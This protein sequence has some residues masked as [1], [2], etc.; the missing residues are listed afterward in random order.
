MEREALFF[1]I[2][3]GLFGVVVWLSA[4]F[5]TPR[6]MLPRKTAQAAC[7]RLVLPLFAAMLLLAFLCG[8]VLQ[9]PDPADEYAGV[10][11]YLLAAISS[12]IMVRAIVRSVRALRFP[13]GAEVPV[14]T[15]GLLRPRIAVSDEFR[16]LVSPNVLAAALA[17]ENAHVR[18]YDPLRIWLA[19]FVADLQW[20]IPGCSHRF[21]AW[22][23]ALEV[24][25]DDEALAN[26]ANREDLAE[27]ILTAIRLQSRHSY[28]P[29]AAV[30]GAKEHI[31][32]RIRRL[33]AN[34]GSS[35]SGRTNALLVTLLLC[36]MLTGAAIW[37]GIEIGEAALRCLP[38]VGS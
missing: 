28:G 29:C 12:C 8:W 1:V 36:V 17:H 9:E 10:T 31:A 19:Q 38:C 18:R 27:A 7:W 23:L 3:A 6:R 22:L 26:G 15:V 24:E 11:L 21:S 4:L 25:R 30:A 16:R 32:W 37:L 14:C 35:G 5:V 34:E 2:A 20:P 33:L 13:A